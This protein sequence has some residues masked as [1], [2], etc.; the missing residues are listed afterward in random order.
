M[1]QRF[2][3]AIRPPGE[4]RD[5]LI[6]RMEAL[7]GARWQDDDQLHLTLRFVGEADPRQV[8]DLMA[9]LQSVSAPPFAL[10]IAGVGHFER[11]GVPHTLWAGVTQSERLAVLRNRVERAC[12][13]A[14]FPAETRKF[15]P[16]ITIARL[17]RSTAP[18]EEWLAR[19]A[20]LA[21]E[22][23]PVDSF[24]LYESRLDP[25]GSTYEPVMRYRFA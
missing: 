1:A 7:D 3:I 22:P 25:G 8:D 9:A 18:P 20:D 13:R 21:S 2:F 6:D 16:H 5:S 14:G 12:R 15:A 23:W 19:H 17:N 24:V 4:I 11:K 10:A